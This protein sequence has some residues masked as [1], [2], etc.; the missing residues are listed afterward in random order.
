LGA[1]PEMIIVKNL[2][3][4]SNWLVYF[5]GEGANRYGYLNLTNA[6]ATDTTGFNNNEPTSSV[7]SVG[8]ANET[9]GNTDSLVAYCWHSVPGFSRI[10]IYNGNGNANGPFIYTGF[11]PAMV[12][13]KS[14][15]HAGTNWEIR[16]N[17]RGYTPT[18]GHNGITANPITQVLYPNDADHEYTTDNCDFLANGFKWRSSGGNRNDSGK[19]YVYMAFAVHPFNGNGENA[20]ATA[21]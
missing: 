21:F 6:W 1:A 14:T 11:K 5:K 8:T 9:N 18:V 13:Q 12:M 2:T 20:F 3:D 7:F 10:G 17:L 16:D 4:S 15:S 19:T